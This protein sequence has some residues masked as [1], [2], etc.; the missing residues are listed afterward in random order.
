MFNK[1]LQNDKDKKKP[2]LIL[3][4]S[5]EEK[6]KLELIQ[7]IQ[8]LAEHCRVTI[9]D[10]DAF[11][12]KS[13]LMDLSE[14]ELKSMVNNLDKIIKD[15]SS[16]T[17]KTQAGY[18][19]GKLYLNN[20]PALDLIMNLQVTARELYTLVQPYKDQVDV[21]EREKGENDTKIKLLK[22]NVEVLEQKNNKRK[23]DLEIV[24][25]KIGEFNRDLHPFVSI[26]VRRDDKNNLCI[27][28]NKLLFEREL[29]DLNSTIRRLE[30]ELIK[31]EENSYQHISELLDTVEHLYQRHQPI[32]L[33]LNKVELD[34]KPSLQ[35][36]KDIY[37][38]LQ[39]IVNRFVL[40]TQKYKERISAD[41]QEIA[42]LNGENQK[43]NNAK[44]E[45]AENLAKL[46]DDLKAARE[47]RSFLE[48]L[49]YDL[50]IRL[51]KLGIDLEINKSP[52][53]NIIELKI[54]PG[55]M[56]RDRENE[57]RKY[58]ND[59]QSIE[60][61]KKTVEH[62]LAELKNSQARVKLEIENIITKI[63]RSDDS[64]RRSDIEKIDMGANL[65]TIF[66]L[67]A[68]RELARELIELKDMKTNLDSRLKYL[69]DELINLNRELM[70]SFI[71]LHYKDLTGI[72]LK[73]IVPKIEFTA[74]AKMALAYYQAVQAEKYSTDEIWNKNKEFLAE[75]YLKITS[76]KHIINSSASV[77]LQWLEKNCSRHLF[78]IVLDPEKSKLLVDIKPEQKVLSVPEESLIDKLDNCNYPELVDRVFKTILP[79]LK[80]AYRNNDNNRLIRLIEKEINSQHITGSL[81][82]INQSIL[83]M[84]YELFT[85]NSIEGEA[86]ILIKYW[87]EIFKL[88]ETTIEKEIVNKK[89]YLT[90]SVN[91]KEGLKVKNLESYQALYNFMEQQKI[92]LEDLMPTLF[93]NH[94]IFQE[95]VENIYNQQSSLGL[96]EKKSL[97]KKIFSAEKTELAYTKMGQIISE[98]KTEVYNYLSQNFS[99][100]KAA[101][102]G[103]LIFN[104]LFVT[105]GLLA[106]TL[107]I[108]IKN[109]FL[110]VSLLITLIPAYVAFS[111]YWL[112]RFFAIYTKTVKDRIDDYFFKDTVAKYYNL[113][114]KY[115][116]RD[117]KSA[118]D[119]IKFYQKSYPLILYAG[120]EKYS[121]FI[122]A[123]INKY[124]APKNK[125]SK[126]DFKTNW[127]AIVSS[128]VQGRPMGI[129]SGKINSQETI[130]RISEYVSIFVS[131][132]WL[133]PEAKMPIELPKNINNENIKN[134]IN[135]LENY[136]IN[137]FKVEK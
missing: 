131:L 121:N 5:P 116:S 102:V 106:P 72:F 85:A 130:R 14:Q 105:F 114:D 133:K 47:Q 126:Q 115:F 7:R 77:I 16:T 113:L 6:R 73:I 69:E 19:W 31:K 9:L 45:L 109:I 35:S 76:N 2:F 10:K 79:I 12:K 96:Q 99:V 49:I 81:E 43:I 59:I 124:S 100:I 46:K 78:S 56:E 44:K 70:K 55:R 103:L 1:V 13:S 62:Q 122:Y 120:T 60:E 125:I 15:N 11:G 53:N 91:T 134:N 89:I 129:L 24:L 108:N 104:S 21:L 42:N 68:T 18:T 20:S 48:V 63:M 39:S 54:N 136:L 33:Y 36:L 61:Q 32:Q 117:N 65:E 127:L 52:A 93:K 107:I 22:T 94:L 28:L 101:Y 34:G 90:D 123:L 137:Y 132:Q 3:G 97:F 86:N 38:K 88:Q 98:I 51:N 17:I 29:G 26:E 30:N 118:V 66:R 50:Q 87:Q 110:L 8:I 25:Q 23:A 135:A 40:E 84:L 112:N 74:K 57:R 80:I 95:A 82:D 37:V 58:Q 41:A 27:K 71:S 92:P 119:F 83:N 64:L 111:F 128:L 67:P 75:V 4:K